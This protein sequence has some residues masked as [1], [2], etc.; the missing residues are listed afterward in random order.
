MGKAAE[1]Q[2]ISRWELLG[3]NFIGEHQLLSLSGI[4]PHIAAVASFVMQF[5]QTE[6][7]I[8][9][10]ALEFLMQRPLP[11]HLADM[12]DFTPNGALPTRGIG[13]HQQPLLEA[14][15]S[16]ASTMPQ[17]YNES[18]SSNVVH[19]SDQAL[20]QSHEGLGEYCY[21]TPR[22]RNQVKFAGQLLAEADTEINRCGCTP[23]ICNHELNGI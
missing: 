15:K 9:R 5:R 16:I 21:L 11:D 12:L 22:Q 4:G 13:S 10:P 8:D 14:T 19:G 18:C 3:N 23:R 7:N 20:S 2:T 6:G 17:Q 1:P